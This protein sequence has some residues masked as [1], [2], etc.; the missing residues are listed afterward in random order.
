MKR[1][2]KVLEKIGRLRQKYRRVAS[3][4]EI[5]VTECSETDRAKDITWE[6]KTK[7]LEKAFSGTYCLRSWGLIHKT[8]KEFWELYMMLSQVEEAFRE[9]KSELG[10]RPNYHQKED[11]VDGHYWIT[12]L[13]YHLTHAIRYKLSEK[14]LKLSWRS[15]RDRMSSQSRVSI[16][17]KGAKGKAIHVRTTTEPEAYQKSICIALGYEAKPLRTLEV[18]V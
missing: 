4:Y 14:G 12:L 7:D 1:Y 16:M 9:M 5:D 17:L 6:V 8:E 3:H 18:I 11:R 13:A 2:V 10:L 15:I